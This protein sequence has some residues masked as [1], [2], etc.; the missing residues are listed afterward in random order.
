MSTG[1]SQCDCSHQ[2]GRR[3]SGVADD[4]WQNPRVLGQE[5]QL[6]PHP[7]V[8]PCHP[9]D[10]GWGSAFLCVCRSLHIDG[11]G[12]FALVRIQQK[13]VMSEGSQ[14]QRKGTQVNKLT[15]FE[16]HTE[17]FEDSGL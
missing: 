17:D 15:K 3:E 4:T 12:F 16:K 10:R 6:M 11:T 14:L 9:Q 7:Q 13:P 8:S 5:V 2:R 1:K